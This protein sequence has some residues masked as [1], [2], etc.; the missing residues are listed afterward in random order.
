M[1]NEAIKK[2]MDENENS[3]DGTPPRKKQKVEEEKIEDRQIDSSDEEPEE[4]SFKPVPSME[5]EPS[6]TSE[7][8]K[9]RRK[10]KKARVEKTEVGIEAPLDDAIFAAMEEDE[11][12][13]KIQLENKQKINRQEERK[14]RVF[15]MPNDPGIHLVKQ[16]KIKTVSAA[17]SSA[18]A[19]LEQMRGRHARVSK[20]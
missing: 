16:K 20:E 10:S 17:S 7:K 4:V 9:K 3:N 18:M 8:K 11:T 19:F 5:F 1:K 13:E 15:E 6:R 14:K 12:V 2:L